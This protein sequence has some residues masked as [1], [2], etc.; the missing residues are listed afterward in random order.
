MRKLVVYGTGLI[1]EVADFYFRND[2]PYEVVAFSN[3][4][5]F[6]REDRFQGR[7]VVPFDEVE[8]SFSVDEHNIFIALGYAKTN[9]I[10]QARVADAKAKGYSCASYI[11]S[12][13]V[14]FGSATGENCFILEN[15]VI[16]PFVVI[17]TNVTL[18][19]GN[20]IGHHSK[21]GD[22]CFISS[23]VVISGACEIGENCFLGVNSTVRDNIK[24]GPFVVVSPGAIIARDCDERSV[25]Q[26]PESTTRIIPRDVL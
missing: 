19:S 26:P 18:W 17:G 14:C 13:A 10:R 1:A 24:L 25:V 16:Q 8:R 12:R 4:G 9:K 23:H 5:E 21:I 20:H 6:I 11:S 7:P 2:S 22:N 3:A 15:N